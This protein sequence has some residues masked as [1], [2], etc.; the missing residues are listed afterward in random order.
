MLCRPFRALICDNLW[1]KN[2]S[3][4]KR[5]QLLTKI[6]GGKSIT[7]GTHLL[8]SANGYDIAASFSSIRTYVD[9]VVGTLYDI[10]IVLNDDDG[11]PARDEGIERLKELLDVVEMKTGGGFVEDEHGGNYLLLTYEIGEFDALVFSS[12]EG[13]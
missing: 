6:L 5:L 3:E 8:G 13:G 12:G 1:T 10:Q 9:D 2:N 7:I 4:D 11:V